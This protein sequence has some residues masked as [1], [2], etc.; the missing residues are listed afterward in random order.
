MLWID[1]IDKRIEIKM[2]T[3]SGQKKLYTRSFKLSNR[4][5]VKNI[6]NIVF[7]NID[8]LITTCVSLRLVGKIRVVYS[9]GI[10]MQCC[11]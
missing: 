3:S 7:S 4:S 8:N 6:E 10:L 5:Q 1:N 11:L 2:T 9:I